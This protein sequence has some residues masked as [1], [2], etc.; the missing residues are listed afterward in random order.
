MDLE[1]LCTKINN[2]IKEL[3]NINQQ[4]SN[5]KITGVDDIKIYNAKISEAMLLYT[6]IINNLEK[7]STKTGADISDKLEHVKKMVKL[8]NI[9]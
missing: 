5:V 3:E 1:L 2:D 7:I 8:H 9:A 4:L 6:N